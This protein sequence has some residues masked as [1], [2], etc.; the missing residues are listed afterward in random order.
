MSC[1]VKFF[2]IF[3]SDS[4]S[5]EDI[6]KKLKRDTD[7]TEESCSSRTGH[8]QMIIRNGFAREAMKTIRESSSPKVSTETKTQAEKWLTKLPPANKD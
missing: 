1:F 6:I 3:S 8:A 5:R 2:D 4:L 7:Y